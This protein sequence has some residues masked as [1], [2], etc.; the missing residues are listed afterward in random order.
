MAQTRVVLLVRSGGDAAVPAWQDAFRPLLPGIEVRGWND[1]SV[2]PEDV[3]YALVWEPEPGRLATYPH[4][5]VIF[6]TAAGVDHITRDHA[7]PAH[8]PIVR[9]GADEMA[10]TVGEHACLAVLTILRDLPRMLEAQ[11][12]ARWERFEPAR[13]TRDAR[14]GIMGVGSI[15]QAM[16]AMLRGIGFPVQGWS[17]TPRQVPGIEMF[18]EMG[19][20]PAF[21][22][23]SDLLV[24][25]LPDTPE[26]AGLLNTRTLGLLPRGAGLVNVGRG[27][28]VVMPDL[29][30]ALDAGQVGRAML[31]VFEPEPLPAVP[32]S[33]PA[34]S[35]ASA[36]ANTRSRKSAEYAPAITHHLKTRHMGSKCRAYTQI[37]LADRCDTA[38]DMEMPRHQARRRHT[39]R[40]VQQHHALAVIA[41]GQRDRM[42]AVIG[43][44][45]RLNRW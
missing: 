6:S 28:L 15:G 29:L 25:I 18:A 26:T 42:R 38:A 14:V 36:T 43:R 21:L 39:G 44:I 13:T 23:R 31:D 27:S 17:R 19:A 34:G 30:A 33:W 3:R 35:P 8:V 12:E 9:M 16:A 1:A 40:L 10:Q 41:A 4:L 45:E 37:A 11:R 5:D 22:G 20:L 32:K 24:A 7:R 2:R